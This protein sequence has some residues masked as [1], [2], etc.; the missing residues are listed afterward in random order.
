MGKLRI[1]SSLKPTEM[2]GIDKIGRVSSASV[3]KHTGRS[4]A[5]WITLLD[6]ANARHWPH[7]EITAL[8]KVKYKLTPWWQQGVAMGYEIHVG[9]RIEGRSV[10]GTYGTV[11]SKTLPLS[12]A[13][14]WKYLSSPEGLALWLNPFAPFPW[15]KGAGYEVD[16]GVFG[17]VRTVKAPQRLRLSWRE[18]QWPKASVVQLNVVPRPGEKCMVVVQHEGLPTELVKNKLRARWK[19]ALQDLASRGR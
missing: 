6:R 19:K 9:K 14:A 11:A 12:Q 7:S 17:E 1:T 18:E 13:Q 8:L 2:P 16:G 15:K 10:K 5:Q 3:E 4:W